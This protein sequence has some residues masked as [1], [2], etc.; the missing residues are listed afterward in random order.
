MKPILEIQNISKKFRISHQ[1]NGY[2]SL[3]D[4]MMNALKFEKNSTEDFWAL[5]DISFE[6]QAG[7]SIGIIGRNGAGKSTLLKILS[8]ITPPTTGKIISR[9]R[10][11][12]LLEVGTGFHPELT[13]R[14]NIF[15]NGSL[16]GMKRKEIEN[17]FD[18]IVDFSGTEKFLDTP[19]K[20]YSSGMQLRLAFAVAAFLEPEILIIDE[21]LAVGD[22]EF[23]KKCLGKMEDVSKSGRTILFVSHNMAAVQSLCTKS[24]L[25]K[26]GKLQFINSSD[27]VIQA[28]FNQIEGNLKKHNGVLVFNQN[29]KAKPIK[30]I[31]IL[32]DGRNSNTAYMGCQLEIR[33]HFKTTT[34]LDAPVLGI[35]LKDSQGVPMIGVNNKHYAGNIAEHPISEGCI[36]M[37]IPYLT[38]FEGVYHADIHFGNGYSDF[39]ILQDCFEFTVEP[40]KFASG[41]IPDKR[42]NK[43]FIK[44]IEWTLGSK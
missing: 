31:E 44:E 43:L 35:I 29:I 15:F 27:E 8:K 36:S 24:I 1:T 3:R 41:E 5:K 7:E 20:H 38:L 22:A 12:S 39:E 17:K 21:V 40:M 16:L 6:V 4:R 14:E 11:A 42:F 2:L 37:S 33:V 28:Y 19:L 25:L 10:M 18:E 30:K 34:N 26:N 23:Q 13:G 32:C 9:G